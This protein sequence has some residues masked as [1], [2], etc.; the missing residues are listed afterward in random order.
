MFDVNRLVTLATD[1]LGSD[2][3][4]QGDVNADKTVD[5]IFMHMK[6]KIITQFQHFVI[7]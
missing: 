6:P 7:L 4:A 2:L 1:A 3:R 5:I